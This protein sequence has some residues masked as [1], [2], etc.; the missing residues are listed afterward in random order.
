MK[1]ALQSSRAD[2]SIGAPA[3][4]NIEKELAT[5][6]TAYFS[7]DASDDVSI[8]DDDNVSDRCNLTVLPHILISSTSTTCVTIVRHTIW[9]HPPPITLASAHLLHQSSMREHVYHTSFQSSDTSV[10][11]LWD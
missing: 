11:A 7:E 2:S 9:S 5:S 3:I 10:H 1:E 6:Q 4:G 8:E